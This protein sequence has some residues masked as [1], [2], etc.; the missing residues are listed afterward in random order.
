MAEVIETNVIKSLSDAI[1]E[2]LTKAYRAGG[3]ALA[4]LLLGSILMLT[5]TLIPT[6]WL[7]GALVATEFLLVLVVCGLFFFK[8]LRPL[9][10]AQ[11]VTAQNQE[12]ID[13][14]QAVGVAL[15]DLALELQSL[16]FKNSEQVEAM[17]S[18]ILPII[19]K[20]PKV[21]RRVT[22]AS[23]VRRSN[24]LSRQIVTLTRGWGTVIADIRQALVMS[25]PTVLRKYLVELTRIRRGVQE[26]LAQD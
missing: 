20:I 11:R 26:L 17:Y 15:S 1:A 2:P 13:N 14:I 10:R 7:S 4:F 12:M 21:G 24:D 22:D 18:T 19:E 5:A 8:E 6:V 16:A 25:N 9:A 3:L 23:V